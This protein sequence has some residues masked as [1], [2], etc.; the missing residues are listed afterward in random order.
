MSAEHEELE[1]SVAAYLLG[2]VE[3]DEEM[4]PRKEA[5]AAHQRAR[6]ELHE[7]HVRRSRD[8]RGAGADNRQRKERGRDGKGPHSPEYADG[9][10][11]IR[12]PVGGFAEA[13]LR[14]QR[15]PP[16]TAAVGRCVEHARLRAVARAEP[17][18]RQA[19]RG[20]LRQVDAR[21]IV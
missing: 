4:L 1:N 18:Q 16:D 2:S 6:L 10:P 11:Q 3:P 21:G 9:P 19:V 7:P 20:H 13:L 8:R 12:R 14:R 5:G 15:Q 17:C